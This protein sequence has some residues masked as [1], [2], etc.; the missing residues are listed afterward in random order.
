MDR[1]N[2]LIERTTESANDLQERIR[3][4]ED[5]DRRAKLH[6]ALLYDKLELRRLFKLKNELEVSEE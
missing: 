3:V 4:E 6:K 2:Q 1:I 5:A